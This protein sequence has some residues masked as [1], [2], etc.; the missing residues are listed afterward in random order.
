VVLG[1]DFTGFVD[2]WSYLAVFLL[3]GVESLGIPLPGETTLITA[4]TLAGAHTSVHLA[5][6][7]VVVAGIAGA[8]IGDNIG[9]GLGWWGGYRLL[10]RFGRY[11]HLDQARVKVARYVFRRHGGKVVFFGRFVSILRTYAAFLAGAGRMRWPAFLVYNAAGGVVWATG[12]SLAAYELGKSLSR[13][14]GPADIA[15][16][17]V[18]GVVVIAGIIVIRRVAARLEGVAEREFP[19]PLE[20]YPG[21]RPL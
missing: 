5:I 19:G 7:G 4:A 2:Q 20:G 8:I 21:G 1:L 16:G 13:F 15:L 12:W 11:I 14:Q 6:V 9:Y 17:V 10:V 18:G 3:V